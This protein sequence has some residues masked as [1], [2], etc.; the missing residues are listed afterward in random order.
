M[1]PTT[2]SYTTGGGNRKSRRGCHAGEEFR[3]AFGCLGREVVAAQVDEHDVEA[4]P[5]AID[6]FL[7]CEI[8]YRGH[9]DRLLRLAQRCVRV[10]A[11]QAL[12]G[13]QAGGLPYRDHLLVVRVR[14][15]WV[16]APINHAVQRHDWG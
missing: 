13:T 4:V 15:G 11:H 14:E 16:E 3:R 12:D 1:P 9:G 2:I 6:R 7:C 5:V 10:P 8:T